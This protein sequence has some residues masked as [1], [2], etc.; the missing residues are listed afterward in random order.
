MTQTKGYIDLKEIKSMNF[1]YDSED[2]SLILT[3]QLKEEYLK[4]IG[5]KLGKKPEKTKI[6]PLAFNIINFSSS[7]IMMFD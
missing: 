6:D 7:H 1:D 5:Y 2:D 4:K 3:I